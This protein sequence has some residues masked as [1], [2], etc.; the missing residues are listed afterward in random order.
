ATSGSSPSTGSWAGAGVAGAG[1]R[2]G[3]DLGSSAPASRA[4]AANAS[5]NRG[6]CFENDVAIMSENLPKHGDHRTGPDHV[7]HLLLDFLPRL[8]LERKLD[9]DAEVHQFV[10]AFAEHVERDER[11]PRLPVQVLRD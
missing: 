10:L 1:G 11:H 9:R 2:A 3:V 5:A 4:I 6:I 8:V 7:L